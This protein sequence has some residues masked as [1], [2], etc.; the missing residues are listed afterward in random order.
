MVSRLLPGA[1]IAGADAADALAG[2]ITHAHHMAS[3]HR[4]R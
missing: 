3:A 1:R 2:A 4:L